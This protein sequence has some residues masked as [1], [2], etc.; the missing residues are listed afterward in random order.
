[1]ACSDCDY[2]P[3]EKR[4]EYAWQD[5]YCPVRA[6]FVAKKLVDEDFV[7]QC[8][9]AYALFEKTYEDDLRYLHDVMK[10]FVENSKLELPDWYDPVWYKED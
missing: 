7:K 1:M 6:I 9:R 5:S 8:D 2:C 4:C 10:E 3:D